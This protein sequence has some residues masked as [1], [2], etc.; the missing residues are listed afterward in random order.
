MSF[1]RCLCCGESLLE[2]DRYYHPKCA[3]RLFGSQQ[4]P[5]LNYTQ[6]ELNKLAQNTVLNRISV[7]GVQ[8]KL[9]LHIEHGKPIPVLLQV[10]TDF[11]DLIQIIFSASGYKDS[12]LAQEFVDPMPARQDI[13]LIASSDEIYFRI[14]EFRLDLFKHLIIVSTFRLQH[15]NAADGHPA[16]GLAEALQHC[17]PD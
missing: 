11:L 16:V 10:R 2:S 13:Q 8:P 9:S 17:Q 15:L 3:K 5:M 4:A 7:P 1:M 12:E 6:E 14:R